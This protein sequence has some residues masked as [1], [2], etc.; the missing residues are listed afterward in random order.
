MEVEDIDRMIPKESF[1]KNVMKAWA[2]FNYQCPQSSDNIKLQSI[3]FNS[4]IRI[5]NLP[6][7]P[8][9][10]FPMLLSIGDFFKNDGQWI[11]FDTFCIEHDVNSN[12]WLFYRAIR[13]AI[14][15]LWKNIIQSGSNLEDNYTDR[16]QVIS[17]N[18]KC[19]HL[20]YKTL[21]FDDSAIRKSAK[22]WE[23]HFKNF[24][25]L[26]H[27]KAFS[28]LYG[29]TNITKFRNFQ[30]RLLHNK[31][32]CNNILYHWKK[33]DTQ[34]CDFCQTEKQDIIH[35]MWTCP[36]ITQIW[37][38][39]AE[40]LK[41]FSSETEWSLENIIYNTVHSKPKHVLNLMMLVAKFV[42]FRCKCRK[43]K[44]NVISIINEI[45]HI[46]NIEF[47]VASS[48]NKIGKH[49]LKWNPVVH[50]VNNLFP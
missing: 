8:Q 20:V 5:N 22:F 3:W 11:S 15:P 24:D 12:K 36:V 41:D 27:K 21:N 14:P 9:Q 39:M 2:S 29:V 42:I 43:E 30:F 13:E 23:P 18:S 28:N 47:F 45:S 44:P 32:F 34:I 50:F 10:G 19:S 4:C 16:F 48:K 31:I 17:E 46:Y 25:F 6:I 40:W 26:T 1:W 7:R 33:A 49:E 38:E 35:L 37:T